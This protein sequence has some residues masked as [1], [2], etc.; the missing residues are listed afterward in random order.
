MLLLSLFTP[1]LHPLREQISL[2][3]SLAS[4]GHISGAKLILMPVSS[5]GSNRFGAMEH[6]MMALAGGWLLLRV[7]FCELT[8]EYRIPLAK[9]K[10]YKLSMERQ[11]DEVDNNMPTELSTQE[12]YEYERDALFQSEEEI[13][14]WGCENN[15]G[16]EPIIRFSPLQLNI[17]LRV[18]DDSD[19][20][21]EDDDDEGT[22]NEQEIM[23]GII[24]QEE[25]EQRPIEEIVNEE[26]EVLVQHTGYP[27]ET[28]LDP[29]KEYDLDEKIVIAN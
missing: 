17:L 4:G 5:T 11:L 2:L 26:Q 3:R 19:E 13:I 21:Y 9:R 8:D 16:K 23:L 12:E 28:I 1:L 6:F 29:Y 10:C 22:Q 24:K 14:Y 20:D 18:E 27:A 7:I 15:D 25:E